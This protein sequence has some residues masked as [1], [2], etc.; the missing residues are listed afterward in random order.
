[1]TKGSFQIISLPSQLKAFFAKQ[2]HE[3]K[4]YE[5]TTKEI[6]HDNC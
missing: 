3:D 6:Y 1:M 4:E 5:N 2:S